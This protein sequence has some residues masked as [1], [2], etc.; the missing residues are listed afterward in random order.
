MIE[1]ENDVSLL[2]E[3]LKKTLKES[4][5]SAAIAFLAA[6]DHLFE[7]NKPVAEAIVA[8]LRDQRSYMK[9]IASENYCSLATQLAMGNL[10][11]DK[12]SEGIV[13]RRFYAG[14]D[15]VDKVEALAV[16]Q[17]KEIF[18]CE[19]AYVQP[20]SGAD[21]N[22]IAFWAALIQRIQ[23]KEVEKL[24]KKNITELN[25]EDH[26]RIRQILVNQKVMGMSLNSGGHLTHG[27]KMNISS[28]FFKPYLF[29][30]DP[31]TETVNYDT[32]AKQIKEVKPFIFIAGYS[33]YPRL[34]NFA[35]L[36]EMTDDV[37]CI[38]MADM[39]HF[40]GLVAGRALTGEY[41]P[42]PYADIIS[43]TTHKTMRGPR[44]GMVL[45]TKEFSEAVDKGC[46]YVMGGPLPHVIAAKAVAF[47]E[48]NTP[49]FRN[50]AS[51]I[52]K[53]A[54]AMAETFLEE[55]VKLFS[56]GTDNHLIVIDV[57]K[58]FSLNGRQAENALRQA[59]ITVNRNTIP[60]DSNGPWYTSG[61]RLGTPAMTTLG[62]TET[63]M[64]HIAQLITQLLK[65]TKPSYNQKLQ[66]KSLTQ[67]DID[68]KTLDMV[69]QE[70]AQLLKKH[71]L[72]PELPV[73]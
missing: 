7:N 25:D 29:D 64:K 9:L 4:K 21:A 36:K 68:P 11:T 71:P 54:K 59:N 46:P 16:S 37:G 17:L 48:A 6:L 10:L 19:H 13:G 55:G 72:Y 57:Q 45:C 66:T 2:D 60:F 53:N 28:K 47:K 40:S 5:N 44:G 52:I 51:Q 20:H 23:N 12:Y 18:G 56:H 33:A 62:M 63:E 32:L 49:S 69:S 61:I 3:Y 14:C 65:R 27:Y 50:Y 8:E 26:E 1:K 15:N 73:L 31:E 58:S 30:V 70:I 35:K 39:A 24:G 22:L 67:I 43:S 38:L 34:L 42:V 41:N